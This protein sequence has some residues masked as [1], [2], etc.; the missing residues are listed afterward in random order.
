MAKLPPDA[1]RLL[2]AVRDAADPTP[3]ERAR[4]D[5]ALRTALAAHGVADLPA[6]DAPPGAQPGPSSGAATGAGVKLGAAAVAAATLALIA[7]QLRP[8]P[9]PP[10][11]PV[12]AISARASAPA[13]PVT[14]EPAAEHA[15]PSTDRTA[16]QRVAG[17]RSRARAADADALQAEVRLIAE[18]NALLNARRFADALGVLEAHARKFPRGALRAE[19]AALRVL[20]L[21]GAGASAQALRE[22]ERFLHNEPGSL[23]AARVRDAC[24]V[25]SR[26]QP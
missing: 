14:T 11:P 23:L 12:P 7:V 21:C 6:L 17:T 13:A 18:A 22:R 10:R 9:D 15:Q 5:A 20:S 16:P 8:A 26:E 25:E 19:R 1:Q 2:D 24:V 3:A 4:A